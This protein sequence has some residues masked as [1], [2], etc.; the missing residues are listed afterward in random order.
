M[1]FLRNSLLFLAAATFLLT[2]NSCKTSTDPEKI[3]VTGDLFPLTANSK[4]TFNGYLRDAVNDTNITATGGFY[5]GIMTVLPAA[6][7]LPPGV[8]DLAGTTFFISDSSFVNPAPPVWVVS[9][10]YVKRTTS[11][12]GD[13]YFLTN[14]GRFYRQTGVSRTDSLKWIKLVQQDAEVG[15][16]WEAFDSSYTSAVVGTARLRIECT[17]QARADITVNSQTYSAYELVAYRKVFVGGSATP[18]SEGA[19]ASI[20]LVPE[21]GIVR[22]IFNSDGETPGFDRNLLSKSP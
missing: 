12:S 1:V 10:F 11:T 18:V 6:P 4:F 20:W 19:T 16:T 5:A 17:I 3:V 15:V 7:P 21:F 22:F 13:I 9:G 8:S 2:V 14:A